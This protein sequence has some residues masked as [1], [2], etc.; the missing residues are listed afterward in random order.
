[1]FFSVSADSCSISGGFGCGH[2]VSLLFCPTVKFAMVLNCFHNSTATGKAATKGAA[3]TV[4]G[5]MAFLLFSVAGLAC[6]RVPLVFLFVLFSDGF[7]FLLLSVV[8]FVGS[9]TYMIVRLF[10]GE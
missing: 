3:A 1:V 10:A 2:R 9:T 6:K 5:Y 4:N 7:V 8:R